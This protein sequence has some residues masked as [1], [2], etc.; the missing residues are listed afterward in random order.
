MTGG[1]GTSGPASHG[2]RGFPLSGDLPGA[3]LSA[4]RSLTRTRAYDDS[5]TQVQIRTLHHTLYILTHTHPPSIK[6]APS[7]SSP[8][9]MLPDPATLAAMLSNEN[10]RRKSKIGCTKCLV[11]E[12]VASDG[13][14][15]ASG[16]VAVASFL[17]VMIPTLLLLL[18]LF[19]LIL[20]LLL[21]L[22][23]SIQP[24]TCFS[25]NGSNGSGYRD[26]SVDG[27]AKAKAI[28]HVGFTVTFDTQ[29]QHLLRKRTKNNGTF[30][31][32]G[33]S[34]RRTWGRR[35]LAVRGQRVRYQGTAGRT[36][37]LKR[38]GR[39]RG[40]RDEEWKA[41]GPDDGDG[42]R[43]QGACA[44]AHGSIAELMG[45]PILT[46]IQLSPC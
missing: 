20:L 6:V 44:A 41:G 29:H 38:L 30:E 3:I 2:R 43:R 23:C 32:S 5:T 33:S 25:S 36:G 7:P 26:G 17:V 16:C 46:A 4:H 18:F 1:T 28:S 9:P 40:C 37:G 22:G 10:I 39:V 27:K 11:K 45:R 19:L 12:V 21:L 31:E 35:S 15:V 24:A 14:R 8:L 34:L 42:A 13:A